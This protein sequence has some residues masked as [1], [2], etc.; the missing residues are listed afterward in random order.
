MAWIIQTLDYPN[1]LSGP[2]KGC[3]VPLHMVHVRILLLR[4]FYL[5]VHVLASEQIHV[6]IHVVAMSIVV[7]LQWSR[8]M[9]TG[10]DT[11]TDTCSGLVHGSAVAMEQIH[12]HWSRYMQ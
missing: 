12:V 4:M 7:Q 11:C 5:V 3:T 9:C 10:A 6:M 2:S 1:V 8:Y